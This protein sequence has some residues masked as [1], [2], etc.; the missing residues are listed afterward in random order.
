MGVKNVHVLDHTADPKAFEQLLR[1]S[2]EK[3]E[4]TVIVARRTCLLATRFI[5]EW[6]KC[7][8]V[9]CEAQ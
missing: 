2:M 7:E 1:E 3:T 9:T 6:D 8:G 5:K 4:L